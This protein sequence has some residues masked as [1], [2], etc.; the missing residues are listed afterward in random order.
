ML[1]DL[2]EAG[3]G[4]ASVAY[5]KAKVCIFMGSTEFLQSNTKGQSVYILRLSHRV[6]S[7]FLKPFS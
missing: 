4:G 6:S 2:D 5:T 3:G 7:R 1:K